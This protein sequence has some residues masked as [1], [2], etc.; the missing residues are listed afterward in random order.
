MPHMGND[1]AA[2]KS[3]SE[4]A[5]ASAEGL[6]DPDGYPPVSSDIVAHLVFA[7][8]AGMTN[9]LTRA[10]RSPC[11]RS[12]TPPPFTSTPDEDGRVAWMMTGVARETVDYLLFIDETKLTGRSGEIR[13]SPSGSRQ[14]AR[15]TAR[16]GRC[17]S[18]T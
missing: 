3:R 17:M 18:S 12:V 15:E 13:D 10:S 2:L 5:L 1:V 11:C 9:L 6:F 14:A 4:R 16:A 8:Q 7:H